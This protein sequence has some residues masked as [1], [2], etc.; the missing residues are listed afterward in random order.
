MHFIIYIF[1]VLT[2]FYKEDVLYSEEDHNKENE[3]GIT[4]LFY[5]KTIYRGMFHICWCF[6]VFLVDW[7]LTKWMDHIPDEWKNFEER[8]ADHELNYSAK[9]KAEFLRQ[10]VSY[11]GQT[12]ART[13]IN[14]SDLH[15][16]LFWFH[17]FSAS[18]LSYI[19]YLKIST[20]EGY[21]VLQESSRSSVQPGIHRR[22][23]F[24]IYVS[25]FCC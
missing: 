4:M 9:E 23:W 11:R 20:S 22:Q 18:R 6:C 14:S 13:G 24:V 19:I 17:F 16:I 12:L 2:P 7:N 25:I 3:D 1:S 15:A 10:W 8:I 21:D 5:L